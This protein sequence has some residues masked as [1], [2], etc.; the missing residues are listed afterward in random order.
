MQGTP[1]NCVQCGLTVPSVRELYAV[2]QRAARTYEGGDVD[3]FVVGMIAGIPFLLPSGFAPSV[4]RLEGE[5]IVVETP[6][7]VCDGCWKRLDGGAMYRLLS[8]RLRPR[9]QH[10]AAA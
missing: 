10:H 3:S 9:L 6:L 5:D 4:E 1:Y 8:C 2:C 7:P